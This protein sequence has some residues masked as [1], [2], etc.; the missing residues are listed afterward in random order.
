MLEAV[1]GSFRR[2]QSL[3]EGGSMISAGAG[4]GAAAVVEFQ[5]P[6]VVH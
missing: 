1:Q 5:P 6:W 2:D 4:G 3:Q